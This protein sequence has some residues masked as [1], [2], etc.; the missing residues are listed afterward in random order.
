M[1][2]AGTVGRWAGPRPSGSQHKDV[3]RTHVLGTFSHLCVSSHRLA[4]IF[5]FPP[6][7]CPDTSTDACSQTR[8]R[9]PRRRLAS[10]AVLHA[11]VS[12]FSRSSSSTC[13]CL[14]RINRSM[15]FFSSIVSLLQVQPW[16]PN[17][18]APSS[19]RLFPSRFRVQVRLT[20]R[21]WLPGGSALARVRSTRS[22][23]ARRRSRIA[24][25]SHGGNVVGW[26]GCQRELLIGRL[27]RVSLQ[28]DG[29]E[30]GSSGFEPVDRA[31]KGGRDAEG[32]SKGDVDRFERGPM[33]VRK[34]N[35]HGSE[36]EEM[37]HQWRC[38]RR[39]VQRQVQKNGR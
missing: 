5:F 12:P 2:S 32:E 14:T 10:C 26:I 35:T 21:L 8:L 13:L 7:Q 30:R 15:R 31:R 9:R 16:H 37:G 11:D 38:K 6:H 24:P 23:R 27:E 4:I 36:R 28:I 20:W 22:R 29:V 33:W 17:R 39:V 3:T 18:S 34:G 1:D 25:S 19:V